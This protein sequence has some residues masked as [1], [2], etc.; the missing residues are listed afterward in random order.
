MSTTTTPTQVFAY[1]ETPE[2]KLSFFSLIF[3]DFEGYIQ[4]YWEKTQSEKWD[5]VDVL[6]ESFR[7]DYIDNQFEEDF[8]DEDDR[9]LAEDS[10]TD[11]EHV[12]AFTI[13]STPKNIQ[14]LT[15]DDGVVYRWEFFDDY[16]D[17][18]IVKTLSCWSWIYYS[19][20]YYSR[21]IKENFSDDIGI[22]L[23]EIQKEDVSING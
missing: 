22:S 16:P 2:S 10:W 17:D 20:P 9:R 21:M 23:D 3:D 14:A 6:P 8:E 18:I 7:I 13:K 15:R 11:I 12:N 1:E 4:S 5:D 19:R